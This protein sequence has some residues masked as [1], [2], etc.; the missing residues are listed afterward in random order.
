MKFALLIV[1]TF[2]FITG[3]A[4][5]SSQK[6]LAHTDGTTHMNHKNLNS[7][8]LIKNSLM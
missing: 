7:K 4:G 3:C 5:V 6:C 8:T 1:S 2:L